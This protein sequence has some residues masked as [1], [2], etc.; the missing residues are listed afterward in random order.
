MDATH[1]FLSSSS[2][3]AQLATYIIQMMNEDEDTRFTIKFS[4]RG[5]V[6]TVDGIIAR[7][8]DTSA[9]LAVA[10]TSLGIHAATDDDDVVL[11][12][13][14]K[15]K[16]IAR[17]EEGEVGGGRVGKGAVE[18]TKDDAEESDAGDSNENKFEYYRPA[19]PP[20][21]TLP[22]DHLLKVIVMS[23]PVSGIHEL[24]S[25]RSDPLLRGFDDERKSPSLGKVSAVLSTQWGPKF[26]YQHKLYKFCRFQECTDASF[27]T[28]PGSSTPHA[29]EARR[30]LERLAS[31]PGIVAL[32]T[33]RQLVV[34]TL[35]EMDPIDDRI[36]QRME[37]EGGRVLGYN[38]NGGMR[39]DV[40]LRTDDLSNFRP[41]R[42]LASTLIHELSHNWVSDHNLL[43][44]TNYGQM[45]VEYLWHHARLMRGGIFLGGKRTAALAEI[46][47]MI[48]VTPNTT[49]ILNGD[50]AQIMNNICRSVIKELVMEMAQHHIPVQLV[51]PAVV[52][53][54]EELIHETNTN[55]V[56][57][58]GEGH[59]LGGAMD[60]GVR[61]ESTA[62][63]TSSA[64]ER[65]LAAAERRV[66]EAKMNGDS[67]NHREDDI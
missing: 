17:E 34:G 61:G 65:A 20:D 21:M 11:R 54:G 44:W 28:R 37:H 5:K 12:L 7:T 63:S 8:I 57:S 46:M 33:S 1:S 66:R 48:H 39:I 29:F 52:T 32:L 36:A 18:L 26:G 60:T 23:A 45:R 40:K 30:L 19:F 3:G 58:D 14:Y 67:K 10:R 56:T 15:G 31:D 43:F 25:S 24:N 51:E 41:Y 22:K 62:G 50:D 6:A 64:R 55:D 27:G 4:H 47:D 49:S 42:E 59:R 13:I 16:T 9:L 38:T 2:F 35:G 53:F